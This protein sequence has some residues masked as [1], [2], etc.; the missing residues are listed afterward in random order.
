MPIQSLLD[1]L[2]EATR[3]LAEEMNSEAPKE[4][5]SPGMRTERMEALRRAAKDAAS[6]NLEIVLAGMQ[7]FERWM[8]LETGSG[9]SMLS[10]FR[11]ARETALIA[12]AHACSG[13]C[14]GGS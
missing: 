11:A 12:A 2:L 4:R 5:S 9:P 1:T 7:L 3:K 8:Q 13:H 6:A 14:R 10:D